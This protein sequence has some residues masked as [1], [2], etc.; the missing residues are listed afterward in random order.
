VGGRT[1]REDPRLFLAATM[2]AKLGSIGAGSGAAT[3]AGDAVTRMISVS[4]D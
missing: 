2:A 4:K 1:G 3:G